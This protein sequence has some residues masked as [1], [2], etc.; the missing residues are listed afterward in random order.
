M[1]E[2]ADRYDLYQRSVQAPEADIDFLL[3]RFWRRRHREPLSLREDFCGTALLSSIWLEAD[4]RRTAICVDIDPEPLEWGKRNNFS[5]EV[6]ARALFEQMDVRSVTAPRVDVACAMNFSFCAFKKRSELKSYFE[7]VHE[8]LVADGILMCELYGGT[9]AIIGI[10][11]RRSVDDVTFVW[12]QE[13][14]NPIS[15]ETICHIHFEFEDG[16]EIARA[17]SYD[18]RLWTVPEV[19]ELLQEA[20]FAETTVYWEQVDEEGDGT[21]E[22]LRTIEEENQEGWLVLIIAAK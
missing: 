14:Y 9:E 4:E 3:E 20:G 6:I 18:W 1:A 13:K 7:A 11:E 21:G 8:S 16:S 22:Y 17:F 2:R 10:E 15:N 5:R 19:T 12:E